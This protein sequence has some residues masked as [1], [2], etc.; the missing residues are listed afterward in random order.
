MCSFDGEMKHHDTTQQLPVNKLPLDLK[1]TL[2]ISVQQSAGK[3]AQT[4]QLTLCSQLYLVSVN[5]NSTSQCSLHK[6][7]SRCSGF[8]SI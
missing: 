1:I 2:S 7:V 4:F 5:H 6:K 8:M 3:T